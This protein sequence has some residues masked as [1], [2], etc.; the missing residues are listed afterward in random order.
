MSSMS[1]DHRI[2]SGDTI[3][4]IQGNNKSKVTLKKLAY[5]VEGGDSAVNIGRSMNVFSGILKRAPARKGVID[6]SFFLIKG[7]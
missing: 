6:T 1:E 2:G 5:E 7:H 3:P 4:V